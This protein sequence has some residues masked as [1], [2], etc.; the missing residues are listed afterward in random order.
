MAYTDTMHQGESWDIDGCHGCTR[1]LKHTRRWSY[2]LDFFGLVEPYYIGYTLLGWIIGLFFG[3]K[4]ITT[5]SWRSRSRCFPKDHLVVFHSW[6][7][8]SPVWP[9]VL[10]SKF[11]EQK[12]PIL[13]C[14][15]LMFC[16]FFFIWTSESL[17]YSASFSSRCD[18]FQAC[19]WWCDAWQGGKIAMNADDDIRSIVAS[20]ENHGQ[21]TGNNDAQLYWRFLEKYSSLQPGKTLRWSWPRDSRADRR[22]LAT[23]ERLEVC[24]RF[25]A[26]PS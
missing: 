10:K 20:F 7:W 2:F 24:G 5:M 4:P 23:L 19:S 9:D 22:T 21:P 6:N 11:V 16:V 18:L 25:R 26:S 1:I 3:L 13:T 8:W 12:S 15:N 17:W 14:R